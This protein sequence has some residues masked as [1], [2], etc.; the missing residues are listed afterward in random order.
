MGTFY[1]GIVIYQDLLFIRFCIMVYNCIIIVPKMTGSITMIGGSVKSCTM[2]IIVIAILGIV[3]LELLNYGYFLYRYRHIP[4]P[5]VYPFLYNGLQ[6]HHYR[7]KDDGKYYYDWWVECAN[8][9]GD[10]IRLAVPLDTAMVLTCNPENIKY[11]LKTNFNNYIKGPIFTRNL[12]NLLGNGIFNTNGDL[13]R[14]QRK[15][16]SHMFSVVELRNMLDIFKKHSPSVVEILDEQ[17]DSGSSIDIED[18]FG[19]FTL[20]SI[21]DIAFGHNI[22]SLHHP[23]DF[24]S[25]FNKSVSASESRFMNPFWPY[26]GKLLKS[27]RIVAQELPKVNR[28]AYDILNKKLNS[29]ASDGDIIEKLIEKLE[30]NDRNPEFLRDVIMSF[31]IAGKDTTTQTLT[32]ACLSLARNPRVETELLR[33]INETFPDGAIPDYDSIMNMQYMKAVIDETLRL[34]PS[35]PGD[36]KTAVN[37]DTLPDGTFIPAGTRVSYSPYVV[38]RLEKY[39][40]EPTEFRPERFIDPSA[41][42][43][44]PINTYQFVPFQAGPRVCLG[45]RMAYL[46]IGYLLIVILRKYHFKTVEGFPYQLEP[47]VTLKYKFGADVVLEH[48]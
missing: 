14:M 38:G 10:L 37:D 43:G 9:Y 19:K 22:D 46:E 11:I 16:F 40:D 44:I 35:V 32:S 23:S 20:D 18:L 6:L 17:A 3:L 36:P 1:I 24:A 21:C 30:D 29:K 15:T 8:K 39:W 45:M 26:L 48:R 7:T 31:V 41:N 42:G 34:F 47:N 2:G 28:F 25:S 5:P 33:E 13:W 4:G 12:G 27:E